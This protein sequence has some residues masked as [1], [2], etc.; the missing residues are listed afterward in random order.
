MCESLLDEYVRNT[1]A[2]HV[3]IKHGVRVVSADYVRI[4]DGG[5]IAYAKHAISIRLV[6]I[7]A[8]K[9]VLTIRPLRITGQRSVGYSSLA[10]IYSTNVYRAVPSCENDVAFSRY[11]MSQI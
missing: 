9:R 11:S 10:Q 5:R 8:D 7:N 1:G 2:K 6:W 4:K 3:R